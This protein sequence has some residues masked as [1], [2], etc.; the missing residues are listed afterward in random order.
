MHLTLWHIT[1]FLNIECKKYKH[2]ETKCV[3][4]S[5]GLPYYKTKHVKLAK[6]ELRSIV[7][8][9]DDFIIYVQADGVQLIVYWPRLRTLCLFCKN[10][11]ILCEPRL[12]NICC[13]GEMS[14]RQSVSQSVN[15]IKLN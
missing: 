14:V 9:S 13:H 4:T 3:T 8:D 2:L 7:K 11:S 10:K 5:P 12:T 6:G 15:Y 1:A